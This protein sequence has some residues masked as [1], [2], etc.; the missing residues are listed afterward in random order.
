MVQ[1]IPSL[2]AGVLIFSLEGRIT[3]VIS[4]LVTVGVSL[5]IEFPGPVLSE[6]LNPIFLNLLSSS[7]SAFHLHD[8][9]T[10]AT[11]F[12]FQEGSEPSPSLWTFLS[13]CYY[14]CWPVCLFQ[15]MSSPLLHIFSLLRNKLFEGGEECL[16]SFWHVFL[17]WPQIS[18][19]IT[20]APKRERFA[21]FFLP[22][23]CFKCQWVFFSFC[24]CCVCVCVVFFLCVFR[25]PWK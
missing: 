11:L 7:K 21:F 1:F 18:P 25:E 20:W 16:T 8:N 6:A 12:H 5:S 4:F 2:V 19:C 17:T 10:V 14:F 23:Y 13:I 24:F 9:D 15:A 22:V 3:V